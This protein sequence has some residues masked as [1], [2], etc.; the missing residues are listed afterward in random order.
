VRAGVSS[1]TAAAALLLAACGD[2]GGDGGAPGP[3]IG[4]AVSGQFHLGPVEWEGSY[5]NSCAPY[6]P[7]VEGL[8]GEMLAGLGLDYNG[9]GQLCDACI[10]VETAAGKSAALRVITTGETNEPGDIDVSSAAYDL[11][12]SGEYPR[13]MTWRLVEC[14]DTGD[15]RYQF[16]TGASAWW[17]SFWVRNQKLPLAKVEVTSANHPDWTAL[18]R[19]ADGTFND[20]AGFGEGA[21]SLR[22]TAITGETLEDAFDAFGAGE[23]LTSPT[24]QFGGAP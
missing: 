21:F 3:A 9:D 16:Q 14:P 11:L 6:A 12:D 19:G 10:L 2:S 22:L 13:A 4:E 20:D 15:I 23:L 18:R 8:E 24:G 1:L 17:T 7:E 5:W